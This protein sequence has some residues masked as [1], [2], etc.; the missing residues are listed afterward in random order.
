MKKRLMLAIGVLV[1]A[2]CALTLWLRHSNAG[3]IDHDSYHKIE[4]GMTRKQVEDILGGAPRVESSGIFFSRFAGEQ[5]WGA[6]LVIL[7]SFDDD[8]KVS[9]KR[10]EN[11]TFGSK[12]SALE[13]FWRSLGL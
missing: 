1:L 10:F 9:H 2:A 8:G 5:W 7:V 13:E 12:E 6:E 11:H 3:R 4:I